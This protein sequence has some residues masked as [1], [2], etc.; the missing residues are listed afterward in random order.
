MALKLKNLFA[1]FSFCRK[2]LSFKTKLKVKIE[3][4]MKDFRVLR[5]IKR[6]SKLWGKC[7][8][9]ICD[10]NLV[11]LILGKVPSIL[12]IS[13]LGI[14]IWEFEALQA[15]MLGFRVIFYFVKSLN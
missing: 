9:G 4:M 5:A 7:V 11:M 3:K 15:I 12:G 6:L 14:N 1:M 8:V 10:V 2:E 13:K